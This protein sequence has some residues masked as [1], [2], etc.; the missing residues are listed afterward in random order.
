MRRA[1]IWQHKTAPAEI[2][3]MIA[4]G[5]DAWQIVPALRPRQDEV[6]NDKIATSAFES[7]FL[8]LTLRGAKLEAFII[9]GIALEVGR[10]AT[11]PISTSFL[12]SRPMPAVRGL[13]R[14]MK[15]RS[16]R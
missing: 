11:G 5:S 9:A 2:G 4:Q 14:P 6:I 8:N 13:R 10:C 1:M 7:T 16:R 15:D 3:P 12:L